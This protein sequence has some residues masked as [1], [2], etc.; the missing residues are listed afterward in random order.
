[1][2][3]LWT[4]SEI[5]T[6]FWDAA[7]GLITRI[8]EETL[9]II[10]ICALFW[11]I[12]K[13]LA[14]LMGFTYFVSGLLVQ[15]LKIT[16]RIQRPWVLDPN[17]Q[18]V[19]AAVPAATGYS[20]PSGHTQSATAMFSVLGFRAKR[21]WLK[22]TFFVVAVLV[23]FSRMY[24]GV[25]TPADVLTGFCVS[26]LIS[27]LLCWAVDRVKLTP[28]TELLLLIVLLVFALALLGYAL[29]LYGAGVIARE[30][31]DGCCKAAGAGVGFAL[32]FYLERRF[33]RFDPRAA[34]LPIQFLKF[35]IGIAGLL[36]LKSGLKLLLGTSLAAD[37]VRYAI[38]VLWALVLFPLLIK[39][40]FSR[41]AAKPERA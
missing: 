21:M 33:V 38:I 2:S 22:I 29:S 16:F 25:H 1:M 26:L 5:R 37:T 27:A 30:Y 36:A 23:G 39:K 28:K 4:L 6:P 35:A 7:M 11:C 34:S 18:A 12:N 17:F 3:F 24:L 9:A 15:G 13:E 32:G 20:F 14:Y 19:E 41:G 8:G 40:W 31:A 10:V